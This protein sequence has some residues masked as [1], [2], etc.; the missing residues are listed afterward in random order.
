MKFDRG[1]ISPYFITDPKALKVVFEKPLIL[2]S[3][4]KISQLADLLPALEISAQRRRPLVVIAED[5]DSE[6][7]AACILNKLRGQVQVACVKAPGF[8]I[9]LGNKYR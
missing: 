8:G 6:A 4:K 2:L 3:E 1:Y 9:Y 7:L 5:V